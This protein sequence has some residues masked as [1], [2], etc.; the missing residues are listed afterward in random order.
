MR[1]IQ[2]KRPPDEYTPPENAPEW[3]INNLQTPGDSHYIRSNGGNVHFLAWNWDDISRPTLIFVHGFSGHARWWSFLAPFFIDRFRI[4]AIDLPGMGDSEALA[5]YSPNSF[6]DAILALIHT[7]ELDRV[8]I[9]GHSFG[10]VQSLRAI[11]R[12]PAQFARGIVVDSNIRLNDEKPIRTL[13]PRGQHRM[14]DTHAEC[15][16]RFRLT[17]EQSVA[18]DCLLNYIAHHSC[19]RGEH[20]WHW[21][22][23]PKVQ[24]LGE[25]NSPALLA[26]IETRVDLIYGQR[27]MFNDN[28][29]PQHLIRRLAQP[30]EA[31]IIPDG[32]HHLMLDH[33]LELVASLK[34]LLIDM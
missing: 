29:R 22:F 10:G 20:G 6:S 12:E 5:E 28:E 16:E 21:K 31:V 4:A 23:D 32:Y 30:G 3:F 18:E 26:D 14:R 17:P 2:T 8:T 9:V 19:T 25:I 24:N 34:R 13:V 33:P 1:N 7:C 15:I 27:S 11:A